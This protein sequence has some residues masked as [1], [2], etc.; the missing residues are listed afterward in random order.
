MDDEVIK[1]IQIL[2]DAGLRVEYTASPMVFSG[3][4]PIKEPTKEE[5]K[6]QLVHFRPYHTDFLIMYHQN[7]WVARHV[8]SGVVFKSESLEEVTIK[9]A[10][11][12][13]PSPDFTEDSPLVQEIFAKLSGK[14][15]GI[16]YIERSK[17]YIWVIVNRFV[18]YT[19]APFGEYL[20]LMEYDNAQRHTESIILTDDMDELLAEIP[21]KL[22]RRQ[23]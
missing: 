21:E 13:K 15:L 16:V 22:F 19:I 12:Y 10:R 6:S 8:R 7:Q 11:L 3:G 5:A 23:S 20:S 18:Q 2:V 14:G 1:V 17:P 4:I 9:L